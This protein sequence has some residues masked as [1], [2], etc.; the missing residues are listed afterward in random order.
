MA[1]FHVVTKSVLTCSVIIFSTLSTLNIFMGSSSSKGLFEVYLAV[2]G[3]A[4]IISEALPLTAQN[5]VYPF[6][7]LMKTPRGRAIVYLLLG[8][9]LYL[10]STNRASAI[11]SFSLLFAAGCSM[12]I[13]TPQ[14]MN[15][16][17]LPSK[18]SVG[19]TNL[20]ER[21]YLGL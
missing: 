16:A 10:S 4:S 20:E 13:S 14:P 21:V 8:I 19:S 5:T 6:L 2:F 9:P 1:D 3:V 17:S 12:L 15:F 18:M 7:P 11:A